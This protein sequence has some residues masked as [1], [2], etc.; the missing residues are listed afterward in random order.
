MNIDRTSE[1]VICCVVQMK[2]L[3]IISKFTTVC[4]IYE[5]SAC[6][7]YLVLEFAASVRQK[8]HQVKS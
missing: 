6:C 3:D 7:K 2:D 8:I 1:S 5:G 4:S